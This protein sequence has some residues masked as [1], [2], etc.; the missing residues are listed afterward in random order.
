MKKVI[1]KTVEA[2][3]HMIG[4]K[5]PPIKLQRILYKINSE[6]SSQ[7]GNEQK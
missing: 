4:N 7:K 3:G 2:T 1:K 5:K 6:T